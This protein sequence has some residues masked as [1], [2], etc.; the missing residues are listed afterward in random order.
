MSQSPVKPRQLVFHDNF[1]QMG[2]AERVAEELH[3]ALSTLAP[4]DLATTLT[5][6]ERI[7]PYLRDAGIRNTW[8]QHLPAPAKLFRA[9]FLLYPF[10]VDHADVTPYDLIVTSCFGYAKGVR[11]RAGALHIC[12][13]YTPCAG[14]GAPATILAARR[15]PA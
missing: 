3:R 5:A 13:S 12:Y 7:T 6:P 11:K 15:I 9:W 8:M 14:S 4:T 10:A 1:C 2:G